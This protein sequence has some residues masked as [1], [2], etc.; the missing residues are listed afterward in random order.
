MRADVELRQVRPDDWPAVRALRLEALQDSPTAFCQAHAEAV[1]AS[2]DTWLAEATR[3][4]VGG[5]AFQVLAWEGGLPVATAVGYRDADL[6]A[7]A[8]GL[9]AVYVTPARRGQ[10]LLEL[11]VEQVAG[12]A[13]S[14]GAAELLL[15]V[16]ETNGPARKA[17]ARLGFRET[18]H[19]EPYPLDPSTDEVQMALGL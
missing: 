2:D 13:R 11:L 16:N 14:Q 7:D 5:D 1:G 9:A 18:G 6:G 15:L 4:A 10:G 3:G 17:Y 12:W 19:R 8:A